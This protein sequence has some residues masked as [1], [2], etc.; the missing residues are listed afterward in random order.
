M[1]NLGY[2]PLSIV[3]PQAKMPISQAL[4]IAVTGICV[5]LIELALITL[6]IQIMSKIIRAITEKG[7]DKAA[8]PEAPVTEPVGTP[9]PDTQSQGELKL[10]NVDEPTAAVIMAIVSNQS[11]VPLNHLRFKSIK[12]LED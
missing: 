9:L 12:L 10:V 11:G 6:I 4:L 7:K 2:L 3:D 5:V 1:M 8:A